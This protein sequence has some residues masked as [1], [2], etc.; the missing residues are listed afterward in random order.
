M[1]KDSP[2]KSV[3]VDEAELN[4]ELLANT[5]TKYTRIGNESGSLVPQPEFNELDARGKITVA[6]LAEKA[7]HALEMADDEWLTPSTI[8]EMTGVK[9]GTVYPAIRDLARQGL[10]QDEDGEY[11]IPTV[12]LKEAKRYLEEN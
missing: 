6:L 9:K 10:V 12:K 4:E 7:R 11:R 1:T 3:L 8:A 2:L 5:V